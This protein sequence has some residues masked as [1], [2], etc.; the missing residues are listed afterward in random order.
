MTLKCDSQ[1]CGRASQ[2]S[3]S[4]TGRSDVCSVPLVAC[5]RVPRPPSHPAQHCTPAP[6]SSGTSKLLKQ[7]PEHTCVALCR[8][9]CRR[10]TRGGR[11]P[12]AWGP[13]EPKAQVA[14]RGHVMQ[15]A[16]LQPREKAGQDGRFAGLEGCAVQDHFLL[17]L[18]LSPL[19]QA[20]PLPLQPVPEP[21]PCPTHTQVLLLTAQPPSRPLWPPSTQ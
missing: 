3:L 15:R 9:R 12:A 19:P 11:E 10:E 13:S 20:L 4:L 16:R 17:R 1:A 8:M 14:A 18:L 6:P 21:L 2:H 7:R 5:F